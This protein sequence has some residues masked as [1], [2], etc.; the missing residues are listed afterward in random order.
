M[1]TLKVTNIQNPSSGTDD[2]QLDANGNV[3][4]DNGTLFVDAVGNRVGIGT[5]SPSSLLHVEGNAN[6]SL[7]ALI[8]NSNSL[9]NTEAALELRHNRGGVQSS[10]ILSAVANPVGTADLKISV[11]GSERG[12]IDSIE[13]D[14]ESIFE[15]PPPSDDPADD[16]DNI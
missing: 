14:F 2:I 15:S 11:S 9:V 10:A 8:Y 4:I 12:R 16:P 7:G 5:T 6:A 13:R 3:T 1:S